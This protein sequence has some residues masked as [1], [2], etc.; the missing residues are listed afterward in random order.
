MALNWNWNWN[1]TEITKFLHKQSFSGSNLWYAAA[2]TI[3]YCFLCKDLKG[4]WKGKLFQF[5]FIWIYLR[6]WMLQHRDPSVVEVSSFNRFTDENS[7]FFPDCTAMKCNFEHA[8][9]DL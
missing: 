9:R 7:S 4:M 6:T 1:A 5:F 8:H 3:F 2:I